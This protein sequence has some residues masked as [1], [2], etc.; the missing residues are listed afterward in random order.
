MAALLR[1]AWIKKSLLDCVDATRKRNEEKAAAVL[2]RRENEKGEEEEGALDNKQ[3]L[4][5]QTPAKCRRVQLMTAPR[6]IS[7]GRFNALISDGKH[8]INAM[9]AAETVAKMEQ[10]RTSRHDS[11]THPLKKT[12]LRH[13]GI[14]FTQKRGAIVSI[15]L[16]AFAYT[17]QKSRLVYHLTI[18]KASYVGAEDNHTIS[19]PKLISK[20]EDFLTRVVPMLELD[21]RACVYLEEN[22]DQLD[23]LSFIR[24]NKRDEVKLW[25]AG[26][27]FGWGDFELHDNQCRIPVDQILKTHMLVPDAV[28]PIAYVT[29]P[30]ESTADVSN[31]SKEATTALDILQTDIAQFAEELIDEELC[32]EIGGEVAF[33]NKGTGQAELE[34]GEEVEDDD[35]NEAAYEIVADE[36][37]DDDAVET[38]DSASKNGATES[39]E[40]KVSSILTNAVPASDFSDVA[41]SFLTQADM[42]DPRVLRMSTQCFEN[43]PEDGTHANL[44]GFG[45][46]KQAVESAAAPESESRNVNNSDVD[47]YVHLEFAVKSFVAEQDHI[48]EPKSID[49]EP[50]I[51]EAEFYS[52][53]LEESVDENEGE[54]DA[55]NATAEPKQSNA[56]I[57]SP[58]SNTPSQ[59]LQMATQC[60]S[61][62]PVPASTRSKR[63]IVEDSEDESD[64][65]QNKMIRPNPSAP[66]TMATPLIKNLK[67]LQETIPDSVPASDP[68]PIFAVHISRANS[69]VAASASPSKS[70]RSN[71]QDLHAQ[72][73]ENLSHATTHPIHPPAAELLNFEK[74]S[75]NPNESS[76]TSSTKSTPKVKRNT[77]SVL[78]QTQEHP[79]ESNALYP[80]DLG[81]TAPVI[82]DEDDEDDM[83]VQF[84]S[85]QDLSLRQDSSPQLSP[86][87]SSQPLVEV[88][89]EWDAEAEYESQKNHQDTPTKSIPTRADD[90]D[91]MET[92]NHVEN[93]GEEDDHPHSG[94]SKF[95]MSGCVRSTGQSGGSDA[96]TQ[97]ET[98][99]EFSQSDLWSEEV[100]SGSSGIVNPNAAV[101][102]RVDENWDRR[103]DELQRQHV[104][105]H[106]RILANQHAKVC[107]ETDAKVGEEKQLEVESI[108][109][110]GVRILDPGFAIPKLYSLKEIMHEC[111]ER[112]A[113]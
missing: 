50:E 90:E 96:T 42:D 16:A 30:Q 21:N 57:F 55:N 28:E 2:R 78:L 53:A 10:L 69:R 81:C 106:E 95:A 11:S 63:K 68:S 87:R 27:H 77:I 12:K 84:E 52:Q 60:F 8:T 22:P 61:P 112:L 99:V 103:L 48:E 89:H 111:L 13:A 86:L 76:P 26:R 39:I 75:A 107:E 71:A 18:Q 88:G 98:E 65:P 70:S 85:Q 23:G 33:E 83:E 44:L 109:V 113:K 35:Q 49:D 9:F 4:L 56:E 59:S 20:D 105:L 67:S 45:T 5:Q 41:G 25:T 46:S 94:W 64:Y 72:L 108:T 29:L 110:H 19:T 97:V 43:S 40:P 47:I 58:C 51:E 32:V 100:L 34:K 66:A 73:K 15:S 104:S 7:D 102:R 17:I 101:V 14:H 74:R 31:A 93:K 38:A 92:D 80:M 82:A 6:C 62:S 79:F 24:G 54:E 1:K 37:E 91:T 36:S 3:V